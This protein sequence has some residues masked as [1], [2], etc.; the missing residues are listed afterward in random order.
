MGA[1]SGVVG[2]LVVL[3]SCVGMCWLIV[4]VY[5]WLFV[6]LVVCLSGCSGW[7]FC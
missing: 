4:R 2:W 3:V 6:C 5:G 1:I 7:L